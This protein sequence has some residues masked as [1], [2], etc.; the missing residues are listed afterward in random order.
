MSAFYNNFG[1]EQKTFCRRKW[2]L[3]KKKLNKNE[4]NSD[5]LWHA[6]YACLL[7]QYIRI[8]NLFIFSIPLAHLFPQPS[9]DINIRAFRYI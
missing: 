5:Y 6:R 9:A 4:H 7:E 2:R 8:N 3:I 1:H